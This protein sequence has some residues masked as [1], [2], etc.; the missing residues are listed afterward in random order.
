MRVGNFLLL[1]CAIVSVVP[2]NKNLRGNAA[3]LWVAAQKLTVRGWKSP[4]ALFGRIK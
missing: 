3:G 1:K 2:Q 4:G